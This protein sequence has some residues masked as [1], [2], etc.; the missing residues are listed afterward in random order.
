MQQ[1]NQYLANKPVESDL[2]TKA[3]TISPE[4]KRRAL[5]MARLWDKLISFGLVHEPI[6]S[7]MFDDWG[8][9]LSAKSELALARGIDGS[10]KFQGYLKIGD[11]MQMCKGPETC[12]QQFSAL[13]HKPMDKDDFRARLKKMREELDI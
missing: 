12:H 10:A 11:F 13:P 3:E 7:P 6:G 2:P 4:S 8:K 5:V 9:A 1:I